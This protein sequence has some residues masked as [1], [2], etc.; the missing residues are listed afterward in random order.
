MKYILFYQLMMKNLLDMPL[1]FMDEKNSNIISVNSL[2]KSLIP[3]LKYGW[4]FANRNIINSINKFM[5]FSISD[6]DI[7]L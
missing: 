7:L 1:F 3:S 4:M 5:E 6:F 2:S